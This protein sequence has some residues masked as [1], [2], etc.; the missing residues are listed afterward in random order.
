MFICH[1]I[2]GQGLLKM[3]DGAWVNKVRYV[4]FHHYCGPVLMTDDWHESA[5][6]QP[7]ENSLFW[8][9]M[10]E[11]Q[12]ANFAVDDNKYCIDSQGKKLN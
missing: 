12:K 8:D 4:E 11:W 1:G 5:N 7:N 6:R 3:P 2:K 10:K 9:L